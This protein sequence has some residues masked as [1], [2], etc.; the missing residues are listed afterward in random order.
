MIRRPPRSTLFPYTTLFRSLSEYLPNRAAQRYIGR[1]GAFFPFPA[2]RSRPHAVSIPVFVASPL[3]AAE[4]VCI[5]HF[6]TSCRLFQ[7]RAIEK[8]TSIIRR[9]AL[10]H[11]GKVALPAPLHPTKSLKHF[12]LALVFHQYIEGFPRFSLYQGQQ[13]RLCSLSPYHEVD[14][15]MSEFLSLVH[16]FGTLFYALA[17]PVVPCHFPPS[18][19]GRLRPFLLEWKFLV[20]DA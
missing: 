18:M 11:F 2:G 4:R 16:L 15:P 1:P 19:R 12:L 3:P 6:L 20:V 9:D 17:S 10:E 5:I 14:F 13:D 8:L 7:S